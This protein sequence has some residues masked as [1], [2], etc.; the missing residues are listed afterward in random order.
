MS[1]DYIVVLFKNKKRYKIIKEYKKYSNAF[2]LYTSK[3]KECEEIV[4]DIQTE[5]GMDVK[6]E[7][8][9]IGRV[10]NN[11]QL[12]VTDELGRNVKIEVDDSNYSIIKIQDYKFP[13]K[14]QNI[15]TREK[16][17][18]NGLIKKYI[19]DSSL[20][21]VSK[22]NNK[23]IIQDDDKYNVFTTKS[24][25]DA[26]RLLAN[27]EKHMINNNRRNCLI[28]TDASI[29]QKKYLYEVLSNLG[30]DKKMLYRKSTT[31]LKD[32]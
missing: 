5:N 21:L 17:E 19:S 13:E 12:F 29:A 18:V 10:N 14:I 24:E 1:G 23:I 26:E 28:V 8:A 2:N 22:L 4:F 16:V 31:H 20:K 9:I 6:Y 27:L 25:Y 32:K 3:I 11:P 15:Q 30:F 7:I